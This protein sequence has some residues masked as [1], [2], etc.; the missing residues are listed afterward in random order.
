[1]GKT[2]DERRRDAYRAQNARDGRPWVE[3][4]EQLPPP[5]DPPAENFTISSIPPVTHSARLAWE[6]ARQRM[7]EASEW[8]EE[9]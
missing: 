4:H 3:G 8:P 9:D 2:D 5:H 7:T 6:L 1:V